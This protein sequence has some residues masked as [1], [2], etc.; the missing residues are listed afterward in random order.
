MTISTAIDTT[1]ISRVVGYKLKSGL[2][3][4]VTPYL[5]QRIAVL[6]EANAA[7]Q[8]GLDETP[9]EF[10]NA[11][12]VGEVM[13]YGSPAYQIARILRP[14]TGN[15][16]GGIPTVM[17]PV[18]SDGGATQAVYKL[19]VTV[20]TSVTENATH[21]LVINGRDNIDGKSFSYTVAVGD[22][23][24]AVRQK[25][26]DAVN[27]VLSSPVIASENVS[28]VDL[29]SKWS[30]VTAELTVRVDVGG[31]DA[32][33]VYAEVSNTAG[34]GAVDISDA[35]AAFGEQWNTIVI[36]QFGTST[37][38]AL[39]SHNGVPDPDSSTG[40]YIGDTFKPY[41]ALFGSLLND[42]D[43]IATIT[44]VTARKDQ[45]TNVLCPAPNS[46]GFAWEAAA[47]MALIWGPIA[48]NTP[49]SSIGGKSYLDM[50]VPANA[51]LGDFDD[52]DARDFIVKAGSSTV[53]L[54]NGKYTVQDLVT[55]YHPDDEPIP[56][57][58]YVRDLNVDWNMGYRWKLIMVDFIQD[59]AIVA[60]NTPVSVADT[61]TPK[62]V[63][64]LIISHV[65][66]A[67]LEALI[68][69]SAFSIDS[70]LVQ[71]NG[72]NPARLDIFFR[73]KRTSTANIVSTDV[74]VDFAFT[75]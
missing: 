54:T 19:G 30:G 49:H 57:F 42:K 34:A 62:Q 64:Q 28:D 35:L 46:E 44:D 27:A 33:I 50:P 5:P 31:K 40:R 70:A 15:V 10:I 16:L 37:L 71:I 36:N 7:E 4:P 26:I 14:V 58:R 43:E 13:G 3:A 65:E 21:K 47:N 22:N 55:T 6:A 39:E 52:Y 20:A 48:Q 2:F 18:P 73:Y 25:I 74:E 75:I 9:F 32:G 8:S 68:V 29:T 23:A 63:K 66:Q 61:I 11:A 67:E 53:N 59:R 12:E 24:A 45:V 38:Q 51:D 69:D 41:V 72:S 1:R 17:Y 60:D 56:K